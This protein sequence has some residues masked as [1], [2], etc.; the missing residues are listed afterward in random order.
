MSDLKADFHI[1]T[2]I[3]EQGYSVGLQTLNSRGKRY[4]LKNFDD[5]YLV[6]E[7]DS[8][9]KQI[10]PIENMLKII[11]NTDIY[12]RD[13][14]IL[15]FE[16]NYE[17]F[18]D[19]TKS[20]FIKPLINENIHFKTISSSEYEGLLIDA[21]SRGLLIDIYNAEPVYVFNHDIQSIYF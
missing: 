3:K 9:L 20:E 13:E 19:L 4:T 2:F 14:L 18:K 7:H 21:D 1:L 10:M 8:D 5:T 16:A 11:F 6:V 12:S 15:A 17:M